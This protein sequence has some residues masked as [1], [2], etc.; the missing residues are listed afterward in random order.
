MKMKFMIIFVLICLLSIQMTVFANTNLI[1]VEFSQQNVTVGLNST[2]FSVGIIVTNTAPFSGAEFGLG[3]EGNLKI[4]SIDY[5]NAI[6]ESVNTH[7]VDA[8]EKNGTY[9]FGFFDNI[10]NYNGKVAICNVTFEYTGNSPAQI[11]MKDTSIITVTGNDAAAKESLSSNIILNVNRGTTDGDQPN[12]PPAGNPSATP[13][14]S[15]TPAPS[16]SIPTPDPQKSAAILQEV[17]QKLNDLLANKKNGGNAQSGLKNAINMIEK[18]IEQQSQLDISSSVKVEGNTAKVTLDANAF[19]DLFKTIQDNAAKLND[20]L[21]E[22]DPNADNAKVTVTLDLGKQDVNNT[23]VPINADLVAKAQAAEI[24][25]ISIKI[26]GVSLSIDIDQLVGN[27]TL[28]INKQPATTASNA[29]NLKVASDVYN[30]EF[31]NES[32]SSVIFT[33]PVKIKLPINTDGLNTKLLSLAK[34]IDGKL[35]FYGGQYNAEGKY[36]EG[37]RKSFSTYVIVENKVDF[38]DIASVQS[39]AGESIGIAAAKGIVQGRS[40]GQFVPNAEVTRAEFAAMIVKSF[41]LEDDTATEAFSDVNDKDWFK[42]TVA[43]AA[44]AGIIKGRSLTQFAPNEKISRAEI[45]TIAANALIA[46][47][48]YTNEPDAKTILTQFK[49]NNSIN[50]SLTNGVALAASQ[51]IIV[52]FENNFN[53]N[54]S[55]TRAEAAVVITRLLDK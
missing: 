54:D 20:K 53:P 41:H 14:P 25:A 45:A 6:L 2:Q 30:F 19:T 4:K 13:I 16:T 47:K 5:N 48:G 31:S 18:A 11:T 29:T 49:D 8:L 21:K 12:S 38:K 51:G 36:F 52:G 44:K 55:S 26:N 24:D 34:I 22:F 1:K 15:A 39:W 17:T 42:S 43:A 10:N 3:L 23:E 28:N 37:E 40:V 27:T 32:S 50:S 35:E 33:K 9:Y 7:M 46:V